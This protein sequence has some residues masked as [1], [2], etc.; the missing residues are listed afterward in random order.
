MLTLAGREMTAREAQRARKLVST[1][2]GPLAPSAPVS[3][4]ARVKVPPLNLSPSPP[5]LL[6]PPTGTAAIPHT[7]DEEKQ[8]EGLTTPQQ[9]MVTKRNADHFAEEAHSSTEHAH[10]AVELEQLL[11][12]SSRTP[13]ELTRALHEAEARQVAE[14]KAWERETKTVESE[15]RAAKVS[16]ESPFATD[17]AYIRKALLLIVRRQANA[18]GREKTMNAKGLNRSTRSSV[19]DSMKDWLR[20]KRS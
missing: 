15:L 1:M 19:G 18:A 7:T 14:K 16:R 3:K 4:K 17:H 13:E 2:Y 11:A 8:Q 10:V 20:L 5:P 12:A 6:Q 9:L